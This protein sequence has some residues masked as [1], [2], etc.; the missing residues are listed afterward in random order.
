MRMK[1]R[2]RVFLLSFFGGAVI[3]GLVTALVASEDAVLY[4]LLAWAFTHMIG[5]FFVLRCPHCAKL[6]VITP[7][8]AATPFVGERC[9]FCGRNY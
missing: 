9:R 5:Q 8:W 2:M 3:V 7:K 4:A 1:Q 6:A